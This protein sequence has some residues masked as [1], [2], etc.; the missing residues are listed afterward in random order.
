MQPSASVPVDEDPYDIQFRR[1]KLEVIPHCHF[2]IKGKSF[3]YAPRNHDES[4]SLSIVEDAISFNEALSS[5]WNK[6]V[7]N[8]LEIG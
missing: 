5:A 8:Q 4:V 3:I 2:D 6:W 1:S 7:A